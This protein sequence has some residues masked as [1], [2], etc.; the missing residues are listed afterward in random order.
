MV[1][2]MLAEQAL[3]AT[4]AHFVQWRFGYAG[5]VGLALVVVGAR[6]RSARCA[7]AGLGLLALLQLAQA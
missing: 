5:L 1:V 7:S 3:A 2:T 4:V 6:T